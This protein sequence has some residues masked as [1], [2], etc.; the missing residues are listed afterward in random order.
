M[1]PNPH[2]T[3][4]ILPALKLRFYPLTAT[5]F[6]SLC[7][8]L[9]V[10]TSSV[11]LRVSLIGAGPYSVLGGYLG[12]YYLRFLNK[13]L[14]NTVGD[15]SDDFALVTLLP[16]FCGSEVG[17]FANFCFNVVKLCGYFKN[18]AAKAKPTLPIVTNTQEDPIAE[19]RKARAMKALDEKLAK[20]AS[21]QNGVPR[22]VGPDLSE[23]ND[24]E[25]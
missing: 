1:K 19:R 5:L 18:R 22:S 25:M 16:D 23:V 9:A 8:L 13:N 14:D 21:A 20:L 7:T 17:P 15:V 4:P 3:A 11:P 24:D 12:W 2:A 10:T 6:F